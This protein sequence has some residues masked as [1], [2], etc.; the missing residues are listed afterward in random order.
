MSLGEVRGY[1]REVANQPLQLI[2]ISGGEPCLNF[3]LVLNVIKEAHRHGVPGIWVFT[4]AFWA[5]NPQVAWDRVRSLKKAGATRLCLSADG[6]HEPFVPVWK[7]RH[8]LNAVRSAGMELV[9]DVR[10]FGGPNAKNS[11][12][13]VTR[14]TLKSLGSLEGVETWR[15]S[16]RYIGRAAEA[17]VPRLKPRRGIPLGDCP[18]PWAGGTWVAPMGVDVDSFGE[19]TLCPGLSIG[20][21]RKRSLARILA[22]YAP[23]GHSIIRE[24]AVGGPARLIPA[25]EELGY[26]PRTAYMDSCHLCYDMR[27]FLRGRYPSEL[28]P[29]PCYEEMGIPPMS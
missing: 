28:A 20:N 8:A 18:G 22:E 4:N 11:I 1:L 21:A 10:F 3:D 2:A 5:S 12:N 13:R 9:V 26:I 25:A 17:L 15:G 23:S 27:K 24:L 7:V 14:R 29:A 6:F 19:V 16:P